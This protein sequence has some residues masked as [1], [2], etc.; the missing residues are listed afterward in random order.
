MNLGVNP[1]KIKRC[2]QN[3]SNKNEFKSLSWNHI[4]E[5][6]VSFKKEIQDIQDRYRALTRKYIVS[7]SSR[8]NIPLLFLNYMYLI[9]NVGLDE[10]RAF[11]FR[12]L[13]DLY[14]E[15]KKDTFIA[16]CFMKHPIA[17]SV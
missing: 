5:H 16:A 1:F 6:A 8:W 15:Q 3:E 17:N 2:L 14:W 13:A 4:C 9:E 11:L 7:D 10:S 12:C